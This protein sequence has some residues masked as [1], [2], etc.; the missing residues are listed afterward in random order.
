M[1]NRERLISVVG[2]E[3]EA[4]ALDGALIDADLT[5]A[6]EYTKANAPQV[7]KAAREVLQ[8]LLVSS[9]TEGGYSVTYDRKAIEAKLKAIGGG[10]KVRAL[11]VW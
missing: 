8:G 5:A 11:N 10:P 6:D 1:T 3:A 9:M 2:F 4:N 7:Q